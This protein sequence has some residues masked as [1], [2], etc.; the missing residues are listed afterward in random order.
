MDSIILTIRPDEGCGGS[1]VWIEVSQNEISCKTNI[2]AKSA[3]FFAGD[4]LQWKN[5]DLGT[6]K[7]TKFFTEA[8]EIHYN[9]LSTTSPD[10]FC[11]GNITIFMKDS[12]GILT[13]KYF[14]SGHGDHNKYDNAIIYTAVDIC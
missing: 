2:T 8:S 3:S 1:D 13:H 7:H 12:N 6:C 11:P 4:V 10:Q 9:L 5:G 14:K